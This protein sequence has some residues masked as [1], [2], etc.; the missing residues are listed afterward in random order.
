MAEQSPPRIHVTGASGA[1]VSTLGRA[2]AAALGVPAIDTDDAYWAP[3]DPPFTAKRPISARRAWIV[4]AQGAGG[5]VVAGS[6]SG[7]GDRVIASADLIAFVTAP[8]ALRIARLRA[9]ERAT[10]GA[11]IAA[12]GDMAHIHEDF[13]AWAKRYDDPQFTG[14]SRVTHESWLREQTTPVLRLDGAAPVSA[15]VAETLAALRP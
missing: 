14:R 11:R 1:G 15:L 12:G 8:T 4:A 2:L 9:R 10:F 13:I 6:L 5:W 3:T 7:W